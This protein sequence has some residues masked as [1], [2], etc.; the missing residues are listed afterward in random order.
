MKNE[1]FTPRSGDF[2]SQVLAL[3]G[4]KL[5]FFP[6]VFL[7]VGL[8]KSDA[9]F[10]A[11]GFVIWAVGYLAWSG[12]AVWRTVDRVPRGDV[13]R[14][15]A[16]L[17]YGGAPWLLAPLGLL[18]AGPVG[19]ALSFIP[20][21]CIGIWAI[22]SA[23]RASPPTLSKQRRALLLGGAATLCGLWA[24]AGVAAALAILRH[25]LRDGTGDRVFLTAASPIALADLVLAVLLVR[26]AIRGW[27]P[28]RP[29]TAESLLADPP[30]SSASP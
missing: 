27:T 11:L 18:L 17:T 1:P 9:G 5:V 22:V 10:I 13:W 3:Q 19:A 2:M 15:V 6:A 30:P 8:Y 12:W 24:A 16:V 26:N 14:A 4:D 25:P 7:G 21:F 23:V 28:P 29:L 20:V